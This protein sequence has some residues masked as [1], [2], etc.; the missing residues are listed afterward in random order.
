MKRFLLKNYPNACK[1]VCCSKELG[2]PPFDSNAMQP[3][4]ADKYMF[5]N[6]NLYML[7]YLLFVHVSFVDPL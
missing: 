7:Y 1:H 2:R 3:L 5:P 4:R 6:I